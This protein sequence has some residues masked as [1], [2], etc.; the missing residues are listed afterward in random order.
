[1]PS[2]SSPPRRPR[3][4]SSASTCAARPIPQ[5]EAQRRVDELASAP[6]DLGS[7]PLM[8]ALLL[9]VA[10]ERARPGARLP[11]HRL[12]RLVARRH[13]PRAGRALRRLRRGEPT[14]AAGAAG[15]VPRLRARRARAA[16]GAGAARQPSRRGSS[17]SP[18]LPR[19]S[20]CPPTGRGPALPTY[21]GAT[22]RRAPAV[23]RPRPPCALRARGPR[24]PVRH[25]AGRLLR[26]ALAAQRPGRHRRRRHHVGPRERRARGRRRAVRQHGGAARRARRR[27]RASTSW[28]RAC[29]RSCCGRSPTS[30]RRSSRSSP[31]WTPSPTSAAIP[32]SRSSAPTSRWS[33]C[34]CRAPS[35]TTPARRP[36]AS[37]SRCSSRRRPATSSSWPGSTAP[38]CSTPPRSSAVARRYLRLLERGAGRPEPRRSASCR[39]STSAEL[40]RGGRPLRPPAG[41][42]YPVA[43]MHERFERHARRAPGGARGQLRGH[44]RSP[45]ASS[46]ARANRLAHRLRALGAGA[47]TLVG[48]VPGAVDR[49]DR[50]RSSACSRPARPTC[51]STPSTRPSGSPSCS[52]TPA[53]RWWYTRRRCSIACRRARRPT[54]A[55]TATPRRWRRCDRATPSRWPT[56]ENLAYVIYTSGSTGRPKGVQVEHRQRGAA[57]HRHRRLVRIRPRGRLGAAALLRLRL[58]RLGDLGRAGLRRPAGHLAAVDD[59]LAAG[60]GR[61]RRRRGRDRAQRDAEPVRR[62]PGGAARG[63][64]DRLAAALR[65]LRRRGAAPRRAAPV[66][67]ALRRRRARRW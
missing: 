34:R 44:E 64:R 8:R 28:S 26:A 54:S 42:A 20:S 53:P 43:C 41:D 16:D 40:R 33:R 45:T 35:P 23:A 55:S 5:A 58:Q 15:P 65:R 32:S 61:A 30:R 49:D 13:P 62:R 4:L 29:A 48:P 24:H 56:P 14:G 2:R 7:G 63:A 36:R 25:P 60:A 51:R 9:R 31:G 1:M 17:G 22:Y 6:L 18:A 27:R 46:N 47:E 59:A 67:R 39:C 10:E 3:E 66:V 52:R 21:R 57:V 50:L 12:R 19:R 11:P 38:T 37:T